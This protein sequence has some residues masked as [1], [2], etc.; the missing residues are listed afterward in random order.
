MFETLETSKLL[1]DKDHIYLVVTYQHPV[2]GKP[3][4]IVVHYCF[5]GSIKA[6]DA[7]RCSEK[8]QE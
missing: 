3:P 8:L 4:R 2:E 7:C 5:L 6:S 1:T